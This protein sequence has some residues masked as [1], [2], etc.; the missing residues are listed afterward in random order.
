[1]QL[2]HT[3]KPRPISEK[4]AL[5]ADSFY[6]EPHRRPTGLHLPEIPCADSSLTFPACDKYSCAGHW[7]RHLRLQ[8]SRRIRP[9]SVFRFYISARPWNFLLDTGT[10]SAKIKSTCGYSGKGIVYRTWKF[11]FFISKQIK[12]DLDGSPLKGM[13]QGHL[14]FLYLDLFF[15]VRSSFYF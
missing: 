11:C 5:Q 6:A 7:R 15:P 13:N 3:A 8:L 12:N 2:R 1:M 14:P 10:T 9:D 4:P